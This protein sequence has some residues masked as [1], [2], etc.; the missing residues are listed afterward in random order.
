[1]RRDIS[2]HTPSEERVG[3][4]RAVVIDDNR[5]YFSGTTSQDEKGK[6][7]GDD[8]YAQA[9][10]IFTKI[11]DVLNAEGFKVDDTV[12]IRAYLVDMTQLE[13]FDRAFSE[14]FQNVKPACTLVGINQLVESK[15]LV[16]IEC[17]VEKPTL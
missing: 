13:G 14:N 6:I 2:T 12:L 9:K 17:I 1:M 5:I 8:V 3:Y 4:S 11:V 7:V 15:M 10:N 16:E